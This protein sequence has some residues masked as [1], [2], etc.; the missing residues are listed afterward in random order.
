MKLQIKDAGSWRNV[1][2][3]DEDRREEVMEAAR[4]LLIGIGHPKTAMRIELDG[5]ALAYCECE[6]RLTRWRVA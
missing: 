5:K 1:V 2:A 3:F 6:G 4:Q